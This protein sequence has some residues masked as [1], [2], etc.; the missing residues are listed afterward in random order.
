MKYMYVHVRVYV[1]VVLSRY[2]K[3]DTKARISKTKPYSMSSMAYFIER[4]RSHWDSADWNR[5][6]CSYNLHIWLNVKI[7][8]HDRA[9]Y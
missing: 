7:R 4:P 1:C 8:L 2:F 5:F 6:D 3:R 9:V